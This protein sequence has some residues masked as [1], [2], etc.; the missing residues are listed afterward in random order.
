MYIV[1]QSTNNNHS[2][3]SQQE[4]N[5]QTELVSAG[6]KKSTAYILNR[7]FCNGVFVSLEWINCI[8]LI[9]S[10][11]NSSR[12]VNW[13]VKWTEIRSKRTVFRAHVT[14]VLSASKCVRSCNLA[15]F[16]GKSLSA[17]LMFYKVHYMVSLRSLSGSSIIK[18]Q[19]KLKT[20][21]TWSSQYHLDRW[22]W[23]FAP[24]CVMAK[25]LRETCGDSLLSAFNVT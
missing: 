18:G 9:S 7:I 15:S 2:Q 10:P 20:S 23:F 5:T 11:Q 3:E 21:A 17:L 16:R 24:S 14:V 13:N 4:E 6:V 8:W 1:D 22:N 12:F 19:E 25:E